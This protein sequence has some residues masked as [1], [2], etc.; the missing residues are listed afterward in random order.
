LK[1]LIDNNGGCPIESSLDNK[2]VDELST[3]KE[4]KHRTRSVDGQFKIHPDLIRFQFSTCAIRRRMGTLSLVLPME[5]GRRHLFKRL[6][7]KYKPTS[8]YR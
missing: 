1:C 6:E 4:R 5:G 2:D 8:H 3:A 7:I